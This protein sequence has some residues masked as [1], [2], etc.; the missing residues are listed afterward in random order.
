MTNMK[1]LKE[2]LFDKDIVTK[3]I[4]FGDLWRL[5]LLNVREGDYFSFHNTAEDTA[6][7]IK[8]IFKE[9]KLKSIPLEQNLNSVIY[10]SYQSRPEMYE[11]FLRLVTLVER[12]PAV[13]T[14]GP[15]DRFS[16]TIDI[17]AEELQKLKQYVSANTTIT[18]WYLDKSKKDRIGLLVEKSFGSRQKIIGLS[19]FFVKK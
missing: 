14:E 12:F 19:A 2:S 6:E 7:L 8:K 13:I 18:M 16:M 11:L 5:E 15:S 3:D 4:L 10:S 17:Y 9:N 1:S